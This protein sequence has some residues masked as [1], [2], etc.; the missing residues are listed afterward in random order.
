M[1]RKLFTILLLILLIL[2]KNTAVLAD[3]S[4]DDEGQPAITSADTSSGIEQDSIVETTEQDSE[5]AITEQQGVGQDE[6]DGQ[7]NAK[8]GSA[9][10]S[11][12]PPAVGDVG[13]RVPIDQVMDAQQAAQYVLNTYFPK[14][15]GEEVKYSGKLGPNVGDTLKLSLVASTVMHINF[16]TYNPI[17]PK[18]SWYGKMQISNVK[19]QA[20]SGN[21]SVSVAKVSSGNY[22]L[23][24]KRLKSDKDNAYDI[25]INYDYDYE[26]YQSMYYEST[27]ATGWQSWAAMNTAKLSSKSTSVNIPAEPTIDNLTATA[28][29]QTV[30]LGAD[31]STLDYKNFVKNVKLGN[32]TI[33]SSQYTAKL[34][35]SSFAFDQVGQLT[36]KIRVTATNDTSKTVDIDVPVTVKW[37]NTIVAKDKD[38]SKV[39]ASVSMVDSNGKPRLVATKGNGLPSGNTLTARPT[40]KIYDKD[41]NEN[42]E[43]ANIFYNTIYQTPTAFVQYWNNKLV[44]PN[45]SLAYGNIISFTVSKA[46]D[47]N[48]N[49]NGA[50][51]WVS[52]N[53]QLVKETEGFPEAFYELTKNGLSLLHV[54]QLTTNTK[55]VPIYSSTAYLNN[56]IKNYVNL[57]GNSNITLKFKQYPQ[58]TVSGKQTGIITAEETLSTGEKAQYDYIVNFNILP[59]ELKLTVPS[60]ITFNDFQK[61]REEQLVRRK[62]MSSLNIKDNRGAN[63]Q[64]DWTLTAR[65]NSNSE[66]APYLIFRNTNGSDEYLNNSPVKIYYR[67]KQSNATAP[68]NLSIS[69]NAWGETRGLLLKVPAENKLKSK[70]YNATITWNLVEGP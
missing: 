8:A 53:E 20:S 3:E 44:D 9:R 17:V 63:S 65:V 67:A 56:N 19:A 18:I 24:L 15:L 43:I 27:V 42:K 25:S 40:L 68:L 54:N 58:T 62:S 31:T 59:G 29:P 4:I 57:N 37:G 46:D 11:F 14:K 66:L 21:I 41:L 12:K 35:N 47:A 22:E 45:K 6:V 1:P 48:M 33:T 64:G 2:G 39:V 49:Y 7:M 5:Q 50:N 52:R 34:V 61:S 55:D 26:Y 30:N 69:S 70:S 23:T 60:T 16:V 36:P 51:T 38:L 32:T 13:T 10:I 28:N